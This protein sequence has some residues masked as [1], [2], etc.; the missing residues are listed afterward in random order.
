MLRGEALRRS[1]V[2]GRHQTA[3]L[4]REVPECATELGAAER[5]RRWQALRAAALD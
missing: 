5:A 2:E 4:L 1:W 3:A